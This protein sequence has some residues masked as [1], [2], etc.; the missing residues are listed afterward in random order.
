[1]IYVINWLQRLA[2]GNG[3]HNNMKIYHFEP[4]EN[5]T[6]AQATRR[7][8]WY[9]PSSKICPEC[10]TSR[11]SRV[12]PLIIEWEAGSTEIG[13]FVWP[14]LNTEVVVVQKVKEIFQLNFDGLE[15]KTIE[16]WEN[17]KLIKPAAFHRKTKRRIILPYTGPTLWDVIPSSWCHL[18][19]QLSGVSIVKECSTCGKVL[20]KTPPWPHR[21][22]VVDP[23]TWNGADIF[24]IYEYSGAIYCTEGVVDVVE[25][26]KFTNVK[27]LEDGEIPSSPYDK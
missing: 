8:T 4:P 5:S 6:F 22:L 18:D 23:E 11:Q 25:K 17:P 20:Y 19:H 9:P 14:G 12:S 24:H 27:F 16:F 1:L 15:Y 2:Y 3:N 13:D 7:G 10:K 26:Y 21:R